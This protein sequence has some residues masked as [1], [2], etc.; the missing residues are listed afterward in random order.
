VV[1]VV[2]P[3]RRIQFLSP[4]TPPVVVRSLRPGD[5]VRKQGR[6]RRCVEP[7]DEVF[8][9]E[10]TVGIVAIVGVRDLIVSDGVTLSPGTTP[11][12]PAVGVQ[13]ND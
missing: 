6:A 5:R 1:S 2:S 12:T 13:T 9:L 4:V 3:D 10:D 7:G 11:D 8:V